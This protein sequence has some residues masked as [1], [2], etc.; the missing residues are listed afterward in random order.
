MNFNLHFNLYK[1]ELCDK[2]SNNNL[3]Q[4]EMAILEGKKG[5]SG[6]IKD[7]IN[8]KQKDKDI[9]KLLVNKHYDQYVDKGVFTE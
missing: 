5:Q 6:S 1:Q 2:V 4:I 8:N 3:D 7:S 9:V